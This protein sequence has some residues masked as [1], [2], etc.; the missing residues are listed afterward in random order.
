M[1]A[2]LA[3]FSTGCLT[4]VSAGHI[5]SAIGESSN[6]ARDISSGIFKPFICA[7]FIMPAAI[8]SLLAK[9]AVGI[10]S[11]WKI[12]TPASNPDLK[13]KLPCLIH[14]SFILKPWLWIA[15]IKPL[16]LRFEAECFGWPLIKPISLCPCFIISEVNL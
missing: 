1:A 9:I 12:S 2:W 14:A 5:S 4:V 15:S 8:E 10:R 6:P 3:I 16:N 7:D 13:L 11:E